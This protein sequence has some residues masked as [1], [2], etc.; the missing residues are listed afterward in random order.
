MIL[1]SLLE[2]WNLPAFIIEFVW[3][4][5]SMYGIYKYYF[6]YNKKQIHISNLSTFIEYNVIKP[7]NYF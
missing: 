7:R 5:I 6:I 3:S 2:H 4:L 1:F